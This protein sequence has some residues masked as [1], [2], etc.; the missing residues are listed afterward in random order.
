MNMD[1]KFT[2]PAEVMARKVGEETVLLDL[3]SGTYFGLDPVGARIWQ[4]IEGGKSLAQVCDVMVEEYDVT[5]EVLERDA[6]T[7]TAE[8]VEK[9]LISVD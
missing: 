6:L 9:K 4:L 5:R 8:L 1:H 7:L 3:A 2:I